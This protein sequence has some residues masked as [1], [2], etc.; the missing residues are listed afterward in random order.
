MEYIEVGQ[1]G[2]PIGHPILESNLQYIFPGVEI[3]PEN[4]FVHG[5]RPIL[6]NKPII[7]AKQ[8]AQKNGFSK[9][10]NDFVWNW[11]II[12]LDQDH[13]TNMFIRFRRDAELRD[14]DWTQ[15]SDAPLTA[16]KKQQWAEYRQSLRDLT[17]LYPEVDETTEIN[18][19]QKPEK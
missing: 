9:E 16:E 3:T 4:M 13:L 10:G 8:I 5:Y 15:V 18:W 17:S 12:T 11:N 14:S 19:P 1:L 2:N 6:E 7:T